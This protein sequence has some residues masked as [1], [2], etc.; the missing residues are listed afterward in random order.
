MSSSTSTG[1][2]KVNQNAGKMFTGSRIKVKQDLQAMLSDINAKMDQARAAQA[3]MRD[4]MNQKR[5]WIPLNRMGRKELKLIIR[6][7]PL[8]LRWRVIKPS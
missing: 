1:A 4:L 6:L 5:P 7:R 8:K 3:K 2:S